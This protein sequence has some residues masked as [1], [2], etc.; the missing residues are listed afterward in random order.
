MLEGG[1]GKEHVGCA[2]VLSLQGS[3]SLFTGEDCY[4]PAH[5]TLFMPHPLTSSHYE[6]VF[7]AGVPQ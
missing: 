7:M 6:T 4:L 5:Y 1:A 2:L 3:L